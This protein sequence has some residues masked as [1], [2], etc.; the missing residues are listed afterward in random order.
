M[1]A[2]KGE[3]AAG[4]YDSMNFKGGWV[5]ERGGEEKEY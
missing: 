5:F 4:K 2:K 1:R 3:V